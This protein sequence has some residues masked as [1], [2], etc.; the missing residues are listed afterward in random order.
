M[1]ISLLKVANRHNSLWVTMGKLVHLLIKISTVSYD[2]RKKINCF[3]IWLSIKP[4]VVPHNHNSYRKSFVCVR[5]WRCDCLSRLIN[6]RSSGETRYKTRGTTKRRANIVPFFSDIYDLIRII[7]LLNCSLN[8]LKP[9][10]KK[11]NSLLCF[12]RSVA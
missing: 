9:E 6:V 8:Y 7:W 5:V 12:Y 10:N 2:F 4:L 1:R 11:R 3:C